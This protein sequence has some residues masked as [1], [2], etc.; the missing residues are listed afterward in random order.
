MTYID[1]EYRHFDWELFIPQK[2]F[3]PEAKAEMLDMIDYLK[4]AFKKIIE[5]IDWMDDLTK[6]RAFDKLKTMRRFIAYPDELTKES[7]VTE[8][9]AG[10]DVD[11]EDFYGN[12]ASRNLTLIL[13]WKRFSALVTVTITQPPFLS[14]APVQTSFKYRPLL[15]I[16]PV[17]KTDACCIWRWYI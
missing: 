6:E 16:S 1:S 8:Y 2:Y 5:D 7:V 9:H 14:S 11:E 13:M 15:Q 3:E 10:V 17:R 12:D 4:G